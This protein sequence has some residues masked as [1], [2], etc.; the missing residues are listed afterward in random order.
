[1]TQIKQWYKK[2]ELWII[3]E[4]WEVLKVKDYWKI[5]TWKTPST[6]NPDFWS[7]W[8]GYKFITPT[9]I[10]EN[11][12]EIYQNQTARFLSEEW[13]KKSKIVPENTLLITCIASIWK[14][15][16]SKEKVCFNQQINSIN[17]NDNF[18]V[19]YL[20][21]WFQ[22]SKDKLLSYAW[23]VAVPI[24]N[25]SLFE[26]IKLFPTPKSIKEQQKIAD[27]LSNVDELI[28]K[29]DKVIEKQKRLKKWTMQ[30]LFSEWIW[31]NEFVE[32]QK[33]WKIPKDWDVVKLWEVSRAFSWWTPNRSKKEYYWWN[34][35][36]LKSW[37]V[38]QWFIYNVEE[39]I[40]EEWLKNSSAKL[41]KKWNIV[42]AMY[43]ATAGKVGFLM[44]DTT[45]NQAILIID[46]EWKM[47]NLFWYYYLW[48]KTKELLSKSQWAG[49]QNLNKEIIINEYI[50]KPSLQEQQKI[51]DILSWIDENIEKEEKYKEKLIRLKNGL[52]QKLLSWEVRVRV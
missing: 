9:D 7:F 13:T 5:D 32:H 41:W 2:T 30:K 47:N 21:Y 46:F 43:W 52:M 8:S 48:Q 6:T 38:N 51:A 17:P 23:K 50:L 27:I 49:Q 29:T 35:N 34:I 12:F 11:N 37:E 31:H 44:V 14:I 42:I 25:K 19:K 28:E 4:D 16:I 45:V 20:F 10:N 18:D 24:I 1:M 15:T 3:P 22:K 39:T 36:W 40:T 33:L 26:S